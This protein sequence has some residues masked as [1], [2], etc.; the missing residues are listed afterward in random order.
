[1]SEAHSLAQIDIGC[2]VFLEDHLLCGAWYQPRFAVTEIVQLALSTTGHNGHLRYTVWET[3][4]Q[5]TWAVIWDWLRILMSVVSSGM[6]LTGI[7]WSFLNPRMYAI[8]AFSMR[9]IIEKSTIRIKIL[10]ILCCIHYKRFPLSLNSLMIQ[11]FFRNIKWL[12]EVQ[13]TTF[14]NYL[15]VFSWEN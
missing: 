5:D 14:K 11:I 15:C 13:I 9:N 10:W 6:L 2:V 1:M 3:R 4:V 8:V 7:H 12:N